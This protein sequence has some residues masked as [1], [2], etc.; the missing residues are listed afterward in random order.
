MC[1]TLNNGLISD[2]PKYSIIKIKN[3]ITVSD[4][5]LGTCKDVGY[6]LWG[7]QAESG[8]DF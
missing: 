4:K 3:R 7:I 8:L 6:I 2:K 1:M 5:L